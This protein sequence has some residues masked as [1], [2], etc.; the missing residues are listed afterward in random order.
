MMEKFKEFHEHKLGQLTM[1]NVPIHPQAG[2]AT[3]KLTS[4]L[5]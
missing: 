3:S 2:Y 5:K 4:E 1:C